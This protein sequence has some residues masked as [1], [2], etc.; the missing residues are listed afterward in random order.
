MVF[1][2]AGQWVLRREFKCNVSRRCGLLKD[3]L[4]L[5]LAGSA[6]IF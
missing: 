3:V 2:G 6:S 1:S 5:L 4:M